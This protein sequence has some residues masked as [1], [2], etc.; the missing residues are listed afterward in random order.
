[1]ANKSVKKVSTGADVLGGLQTSRY[2]K[3]EVAYG[4]IPAAAYAIGDTLVF[5]GVP[6]FKI[7]EGT[8]TIHA[9]SPVT[10]EILPGTSLD[11]PLSMVSSTAEDISYV[12]HYIRGAGKTGSGAS[13]G[14]LLQVTIS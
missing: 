9:A 4:V 14:D 6:S 13:Q 5:D 10:L 1:M 12:L 2:E 8:V 11:S 3:S 7:F